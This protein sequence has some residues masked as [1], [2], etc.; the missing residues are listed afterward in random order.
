MARVY[1]DLLYLV[2]GI[3]ISWKCE[4]KKKNKKK[5]DKCER[6]NIKTKNLRVVHS[7]LFVDKIFQFSGCIRD[8]FFFFFFQIVKFSSQLIWVHGITVA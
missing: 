4:T 2:I 1:L 8:F 5:P 3:D 6:K 7:G